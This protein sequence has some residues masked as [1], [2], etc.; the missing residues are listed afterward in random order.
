MFHEYSQTSYRRSAV[1]HCSDISYPPKFNRCLQYGSSEVLVQHEFLVVSYRRIFPTLTAKGIQCLSANTYAI[2]L[3]EANAD[4]LWFLVCITCFD[5]EALFIS[6]PDED[7]EHHQG[8][9]SL[10]CFQ[11]PILIPSANRTQA[12]AKTMALTSLRAEIDELKAQRKE[13][14][15][16]NAFHEAAEAKMKEEKFE[17][18]SKLQSLT[19]AVEV[20]RDVEDAL[21]GESNLL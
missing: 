5:V 11:L 10:L 18:Q 1:N 9:H 15:K 8:R 19:K 14:R 2:H 4:E 12:L 6:S 7:I 3:L 13:L 16:L 17:T 21:R 20:L